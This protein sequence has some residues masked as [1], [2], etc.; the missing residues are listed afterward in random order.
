MRSEIRTIED[1]RS[2]ITNAPIVPKPL[3]K[4]L[5]YIFGWKSFVEPWLTNPQLTNHSKYHS[6][7]WTREDGKVKFRAKRLPQDSSLEP[8]CGIRLLQD[9]IEFIPVGSADF[10]VE[11]I[12]FARI[13]KTISIIAAKLTLVDKIKLQESWDRLEESLHS[14]ASRRER[15]R[16]MNLLDLPKQATS[17]IEVSCELIEDV[18]SNA[19]SGDMYDECIEEGSLEEIVENIDVCV[20]TESNQGRPWVGRVKEMLPG[21][22]FVIHWFGRKA[23][24]G[25]VF[26]GL[27]NSDGT[28]QLTSLDLDTIMFWG[29]SENVCDETF[30]ISSFWLE[31]I[32]LEYEKL[33][34][35]HL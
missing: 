20:Y 30:A 33:D 13:K 23:G 34:R 18:D 1:L 22:R 15:L 5:E 21:G 14:V 19:I 7:L 32:R 6:F 29:F 9:E 2:K 35:I 8:R 16:H 12:P 31:T 11:N 24:R 26:K 25:H 4:S 17:G 10:R 28:C 3:C 27:R